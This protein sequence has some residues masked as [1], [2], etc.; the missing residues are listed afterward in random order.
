M[1]LE[2]QQEELF[3]RLNGGPRRKHVAEEKQP[4]VAVAGAAVSSVSSYK[5][6]PPGTPPRAADGHLKGLAIQLPIS[7]P[8]SPPD[9]IDN[10]RFSKLSERGR[11]KLSS[12]QKTPVS[13]RETQ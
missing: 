4:S 11:S 1:F 8:C 7:T 13:K 6:T 5:S 10:P 12:Q 9:I 2:T 3:E